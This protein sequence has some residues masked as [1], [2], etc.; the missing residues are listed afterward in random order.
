[1]TR[2]S[3]HPNVVDL[4]AVYEEE[5]DVHLV[6]ELCAGG[7]LFHQLEKHGQFSESDATVLFRHL[8]LVVLYCHESGVVHRDLKPENILLAFFSPSSVVE[9]GSCSLEFLAS[10]DAVHQETSSGKLLAPIVRFP[11]I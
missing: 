10:I 9:E 11:F 5:E 2:L 4:K 3:G 7:E 1:M 8:I 6:M